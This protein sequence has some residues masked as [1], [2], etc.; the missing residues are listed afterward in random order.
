MKD[1]YPLFEVILEFNPKGIKRL[2][3]HSSTITDCNE[4]FADSIGYAREELIGQPLNTITLSEDVEDFSSL[5]LK[6]GKTTQ[7]QKL[8]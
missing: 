3:L 8:D 5:I 2:E 7:S 1:D 4:E 6:N